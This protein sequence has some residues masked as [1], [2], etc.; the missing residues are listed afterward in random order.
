[1]LTSSAPLCET[2]WERD[3]QQ[4]MQGIACLGFAPSWRSLVGRDLVLRLLNGL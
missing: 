4:T 2:T 1:M 3:S